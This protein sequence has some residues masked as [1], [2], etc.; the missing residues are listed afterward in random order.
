[1]KI[2]RLPFGI[3]AIILL[4]LALPMAS[5]EL[6]MS[7]AI[8]DV[9]MNEDETAL[10]RINLNDYFT[11]DYSQ[12]SFSSVST[13]N[14]IEVM[15]HKDGGVDFSAPKD[16]YGTDGVTFIA[17]DGE[18]QISDTILVKVEP[19]NDPVF[20]FMPLPDFTFEEDS[21]L[22]GAMNLYDHFQDIDSTMAFSYS[23]VNIIVQINDNG[24]VDF[25]APNNW[26]GTEEVIFSASDGE[27]EVSDDV[28][29]T[30]TA[31]NDAPRCEVNIASI[32]LNAEQ[33]S[34]ILVLGDYFTDVD[35]EVLTYKIAGNKKIKAD[36]NAQEGQLILK[37]PEGW[38]GEEV[39]ILTAEDSSGGA[40]SVQMVVIVIHGTDSSGQIFYLFGLV[41]AVAIAGVRLQLA[42]KKR[43]LKS[44]VKLS[45]YRHYR[46]E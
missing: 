44:P 25:S 17:S 22:E 2:G 11:N 8:P 35:D 45:S 19:V 38:S 42:G 28:L 26:Y 36:I 3:F 40:S 9:T 23:S 21:N 31:L 24:Y 4:I 13:H 12:I 39:I 10:S 30:I 34:K 15:I 43:A 46:D 33:H 27:F 37:A 5:A 7:E 1:M 18:H 29:V 14:K 41:L 32:S 6:T 20:L 16:W